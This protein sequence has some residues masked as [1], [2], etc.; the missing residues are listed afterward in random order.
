MTGYGN[1]PGLMVLSL[2][3][4]FEQIG[5][6]SEKHWEVNC[7]YIEV[8]RGSRLP[9]GGPCPMARLDRA[10]YAAS[11]VGGLLPSLRGCGPAVSAAIL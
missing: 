9:M 1:D 7:T 4:V 8:R 11:W 3:D 10:P 5:R 6:D 2:R